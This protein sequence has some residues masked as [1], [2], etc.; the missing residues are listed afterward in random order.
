MERKR[1]Y[2]LSIASF[3]FPEIIKG[4]E[5]VG[6]FDMPIIRPNYSIPTVVETTPFDRIGDD[7]SN[8][9]SLVVFYINDNRF[10]NRLSHPWSYTEK[11]RQFNGMVAPDLSQYINMD[12]PR[13]LS[14][15]YWN[16]A[17]AA[18]WQHENINVYPNVTWSLPDSYDYSMAGLPR[19]SVIAINSMGV[20]KYNYSKALWLDGYHYMVKALDP[21]CILRYGPKIFGE[22]ENRSIYLNNTQL[23]ILRNGSKRK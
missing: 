23:N 21:I 9:N 16:K 3:C 12:Y 17:F 13:R 7:K 1:H 11:L 10:F 15:C 20:L 2:R 6:P 18:Y 19:N 4:L 8:Y 22:D 5:K 14:N